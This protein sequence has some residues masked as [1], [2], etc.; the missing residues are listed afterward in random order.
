MAYQK[1]ANDM[2]AEGGFT[3]DF[4]ILSGITKQEAMERHVPKLDTRVGSDTS[5]MA[6]VVVTR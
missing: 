2:H 3:I 1:I 6:L 4:S 5:D